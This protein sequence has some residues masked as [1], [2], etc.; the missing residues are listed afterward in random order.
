[1]KKIS[2]DYYEG[3]SF[4]IATAIFTCLGFDL[5]NEGSWAYLG[6]VMVVLGISNILKVEL[7]SDKSDKK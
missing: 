4:G 1:M 6:I 5:F 3:F 2:K 7:L